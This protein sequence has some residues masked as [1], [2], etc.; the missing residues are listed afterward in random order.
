MYNML[1]SRFPGI[2]HR[3]PEMQLF[4]SDSRPMSYSA[5]MICE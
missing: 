1:L 5:K 3:K 4:T 2:K